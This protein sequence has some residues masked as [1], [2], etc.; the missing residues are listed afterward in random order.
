MIVG[1]S[2]R[3]NSVTMLFRGDG[4]AR[5]AYPACNCGKSVALSMVY[6]SSPRSVFQ[7]T[8]CNA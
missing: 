7:R 1:R 8:N 5:M 6:V 2:S 3:L 4:I